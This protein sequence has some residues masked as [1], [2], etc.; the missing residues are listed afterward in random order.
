M[1]E[2]VQRVVQRKA[3]RRTPEH[4]AVRDASRS[5]SLDRALALDA[6]PSPAAQFAGLPTAGT[7]GMGSA[8]GGCGGCVV[9]YQVAHSMGAGQHRGHR[10]ASSRV[11]RRGAQQRRTALGVQGTDAGRDV[12]RPRGRHSRPADRGARRGQ[13]GTNGGK[14][15]AAM[16]CVC[17]RRSSRSPNRRHEGPAGRPGPGVDGSTRIGDEARPAA[18]LNVTW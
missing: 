10:A 5:P 4:G 13:G 6:Q 2:R 14:T 3:P 7:R 12:L 8:G 9:S 16:R 11:L 18:S 1:G 15:G 17:V